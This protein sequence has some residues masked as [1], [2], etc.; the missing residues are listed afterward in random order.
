MK[1]SPFDDTT[2][3]LFLPIP[4]KN[5]KSKLSVFLDDFVL[6]ISKSRD[7]IQFPQLDPTAVCLKWNNH[8]T[9]LLKVFNRLLGSEQ[10]TDV[11]LAAEGRTLR[12]HKVVLSA[13]SSYFEQLFSSF[14]EKNQIV[15]LKDTKFDD[16]AAIIEFMYKGEIS[17]IQEQLS[18]RSL[19]L[20]KNLKVK[21]LA[22]V[23]GDEK[24]S[25]P[26]SSS[27]SPSTNIGH[28]II[29]HQT[30]HHHPSS[31]GSS[32][33]SSGSSGNGSKVSSLNSEHHQ[34]HQSYSQQCVPPPR[35]LE[36]PR[37]SLSPP[38]HAT[39]PAKKRGRPRLSELREQTKTYYKK[40]GSESTSS[41]SNNKSET[42]LNNKVES[43]IRSVEDGMA[44]EELIKTEQLSYINED[45][46][47][48]PGGPLTM[49]RIQDL[50]VIKMNDYLMSGTRQQFWDEYFI[51]VVMQG[52]RNKEIDMKSAA[53]ILGVSYGTLYG[54]YRETF[55]YLKTCLECRRT[56]T[57][58]P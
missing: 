50:G 25:S 17:I 33:T 40:R 20:L 41:S 51:K 53:E 9:N 38:P 10:F 5:N 23:S 43:L 12:G 2:T 11:L 52:V 29:N 27:S 30:L 19:K 22:E 26:T 45:G 37:D 46:A 39:A 6:K 42:L 55:G 48:T 14:N 36:S 58:D 7:G 15:I 13:C 31:C 47:P 44:E 24:N 49:E 3:K 8:Q 4:F 35:H 18:P 54:R 32:N 1:R 21:G 34:H 57:K 16:L 28:T 56:T